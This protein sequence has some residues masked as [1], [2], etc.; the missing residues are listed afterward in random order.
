MLS[1]LWWLMSMWDR[2]KFCGFTDIGS[3]VDD[4]PSPLATEALVFMAVWVNGHWKVPLGYFL[5]D[6][7]SSSERANLV[8]NCLL[9]LHDVGVKTVSLTCHGPCCNQSML[10]VLGA[11]LTA[12]NM[13]PSFPHSGSKTERFYVILDIC[14]NLKII[15]NTLAKQSTIV[16]NEG[17]KIR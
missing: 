2:N 7:M 15:R 17:G 10:K 12:E 1:V 8:S 16:D 11:N 5:I 14:F 3:G 9:K 13:V 4:D 6:S